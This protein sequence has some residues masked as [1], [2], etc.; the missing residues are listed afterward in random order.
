MIISSTVCAVYPEMSAP[1]SVVFAV[2]AAVLFYTRKYYKYKNINTVPLALFCLFAAAMAAV[3]LCAMTFIVKPLQSEFDGRLTEFSGTVISEPVTASQATTFEVQTDEINGSPRRVKLRVMT[4]VVPNGG[5]YS[6]I[7]GKAV[8]YGVTRHR[9][10]YFAHGIFLETNATPSEDVFITLS[11]SGSVGFR[12]VLYDM[13]CRV[14]RELSKVLSNDEAVLCSAMITGSREYISSEITAAFN[15]IGISHLLAVSGLHMS[16][17][18]GLLYIITRPIPLPRLRY[19]VNIVFLVLFA[20]FTGMSYSVMRSLLMFIIVELGYML[21]YRPDPLNSIG[22]AA[23]VICIYPF[24]AGDIGML[25]SFSCIT[26]ISVFSKPISQ[27]LVSAKIFESEKSASALSAVI[28]SFIGSMPLF[29][30]SSGRISLLTIPANLLIVPSA[31]VLIC[32]GVL[33]SVL[34]FAGLHEFAKILM[35]LSGVIAK[36]MILAAKYLAQ[37]K[38]MGTPIDK[39]FM[40]TLLIVIIISAA[41]LFVWKGKKMTFLEMLSVAMLAAAFYCAVFASFPK[42]VLSVLDVGDGITAV[43]KRSDSA[44]VLCSFGQSGQYATISSELDRSGN[45]AAVADIRTDN[46]YNYCRR[47]AYDYDPGAIIV[48]SEHQ[49]DYAWNKYQG[50]SVYTAKE[51]EIIDICY[52]VFADIY[53]KE[54]IVCEMIYVGSQR[55]LI[56]YGAGDIP[57]SMKTPD[58]AVLCDARMISQLSADTEVILSSYAEQDV[59]SDVAAATC[60]EG[61]IDITFENGG[62]KYSREYTGGVITYAGDNRE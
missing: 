43:L 37:L 45:V 4:A 18:S 3:N 26:S 20:F 44:Y 52:G 35:F 34:S 41:V 30:I 58:I 23:F 40:T 48:R 56:C 16:I 54:N 25:W 51:Y 42:T 9:A 8:F 61:R 12:S 47:I 22:A 32:A 2:L 50:A 10:Y 6:D 7:S 28:C 27:I 46:S 19:A 24:A 60:G 15:A 11:E 33:S 14:R 55:V 53:F 36:Y 29:V 1:I 39:R 31:G 59:S 57:E 62:Y 5:I 49:N 38:G 21:N 17:I 13:R